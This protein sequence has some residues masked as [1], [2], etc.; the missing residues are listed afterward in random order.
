[1]VERTSNPK[2]LNIAKSRSGAVTVMKFSGDLDLQSL[3]EAKKSL[4]DLM[5]A[6]QVKI[7]LDVE[8]VDYIDSS[9]LGFLIGSL[10]RVRELKGEMKL[11]GLNAYMLGI[12]RLI[13]LDYVLPIFDSVEKAMASFEE[14][15]GRAK[16][17]A[18]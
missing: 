11:V 7:L 4:A 16:Q 5:D 6:G 15:K 18:H 14:K 9:G 8:K 2:P 3:P 10:K 13:H 1:M 17:A 12:F